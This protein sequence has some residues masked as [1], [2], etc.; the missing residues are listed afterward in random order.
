MSINN[1]QKQLEQYTAGRSQEV[2]IV[3]I[4][5]EGTQEEIVIFKGFS[6][7]LSRATQY[8]PDMPVIPDEA[9]VVSIDRLK[10]PYDP[11]QPQ[12]IQQGLSWEEFMN[13]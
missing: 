3:T 6:S 9:E 10:A 4:E 1:I 11:T 8:D 7:C 5:V 12:F 13:L 2:L